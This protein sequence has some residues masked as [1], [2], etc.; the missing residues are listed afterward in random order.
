MLNMLM[1]A[2]RLRRRH[3]ILFS[4]KLLKLRPLQPKMQLH[5][6]DRH[7]RL[8]VKRQLKMPTILVRSASQPT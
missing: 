6:R 2:A 1:L 3:E 4:A 5:Q 8:H 7:A